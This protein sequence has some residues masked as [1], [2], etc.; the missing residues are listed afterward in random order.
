MRHLGIFPHPNPS[1]SAL[2]EGLIVVLKQAL[3]AYLPLSE[4]AEERGDEPEPRVCRKPSTGFRMISF[5]LN[6]L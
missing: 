3:L 6:S 1:P 2:G 5:I 4:C